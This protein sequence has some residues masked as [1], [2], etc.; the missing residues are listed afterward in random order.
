MSETFRTAILIPARDEEAALPR[1]FS[2]LVGAEARIV[3]V[4]NG[5]RDATAEVAIRLGATVVSEPRAGYGRACLAGIAALAADPPD[6]LVFLDAD[7]FLAPAQL[8][9]LIDPIRAG[10]ADVVVGERTTGGRDGGVR[11]HA[12]LGNRLVLAILRVAYGSSVRDMG[13]FRAIRWGA[14]ES[15]SLDDPTFGWY[16]QMQVRALRRG[17]RV[18]GTPVMFERRGIGRS[19]VSGN[20]VASARAGWVML[21]T[22]AVEC[23]RRPGSGRAGR[24]AGP[25]PGVEDEVDR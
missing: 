2:A 1:L 21:R 18:I 25:R 9:R 5:S 13:P 4:D 8:S 7:D 23:L 3:V 11:L 6:A 16:V 12:R 24:R 17:L 10:V 14:L 19:K 22:L 15:L 20:A